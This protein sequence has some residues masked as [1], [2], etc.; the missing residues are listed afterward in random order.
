MAKAMSEQR[1]FEDI[2]TGQDL[3]T[4]KEMIEVGEIKAVI[5]KRYSLEQVPDA[6]RYVESGQKKGNV[7]IQMLADNKTDPMGAG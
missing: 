4:L 7:V 6:H 1:F 3:E 2:E 5:D